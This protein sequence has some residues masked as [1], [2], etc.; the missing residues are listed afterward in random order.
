V[1]SVIGV[2]FNYG[3]EIR[4]E[5][6][7]IDSGGPSGGIGYGRARRKETSPNGAQFPDRGAVSAHDDSSTGFYLTQYRAGLI[8]KLPLGDGPAFHAD[9][10]SIC[11]TS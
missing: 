3:I 1:G 9:N 4:T 6:S 8:T 10:R 7:G 2:R 5:L 11:S